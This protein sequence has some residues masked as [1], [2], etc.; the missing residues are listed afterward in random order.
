MLLIGDRVRLTVP[1]GFITRLFFVGP[2]GLLGTF[3]GY[4]PVAGCQEL[5]PKIRL[6]YPFTF[7]GHKY[8]FVAILGR[9]RGETWD[10]S[11]GRCNLYLIQMGS[12]EDTVPQRPMSA[13]DLLRL[14][15]NAQYHVLRQ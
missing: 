1:P 8:F 11:C 6:D 9:T 4:C 3:V 12:Q 15:G 13:R 14:D 7:E 5:I 10:T 2:Q